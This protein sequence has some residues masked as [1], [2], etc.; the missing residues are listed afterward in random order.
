MHSTAALQLYLYDLLCMQRYMCSCTSYDCSQ[1]ADFP[2]SV[3]FALKCSAFCRC[4]A[5]CLLPPD[6]PYPVQPLFLPRT[7]EY[8]SRP[9]LLRQGQVP[10]KLQL[11][12]TCSGP[13]LSVVAV[14]CNHI[15]D[16][17]R[18]TADVPYTL[19]SLGPGFAYSHLVIPRPYAAP[20]MHLPLVESRTVHPG[21]SSPYCEGIVRMGCSGGSPM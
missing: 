13:P 11:G 9:A 7:L 8:D 1:A 19:R 10:R 6:V 16:T 12:L 18:E 15:S 21:G 17:V 4:L 14:L 3:H 2:A 5:G 20:L